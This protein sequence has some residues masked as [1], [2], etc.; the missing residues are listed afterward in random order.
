[1]TFVSSGASA[2]TYSF[3]NSYP[4]TPSYGIMI[5]SFF[6]EVANNGQNLSYSIYQNKINQTSI[7]IAFVPDETS[8]LKSFTVENTIIISIGDPLQIIPIIRLDN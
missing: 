8:Q 3:V 5:K 4:S 6:S 7:E 1:M 2:K